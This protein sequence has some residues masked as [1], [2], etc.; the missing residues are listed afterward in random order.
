M[1][2]AVQGRDVDHVGKVD[3]FR[4]LEDWGVFGKVTGDALTLLVPGDDGTTEI[5]I[6]R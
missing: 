5:K 6:E 1:R 2:L 4:E 3:G